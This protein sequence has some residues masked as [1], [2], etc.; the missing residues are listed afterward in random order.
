[1]D[2]LPQRAISW[3]FPFRKNQGGEISKVAT[4]KSG[5]PGSS[6][7]VREQ[8]E[9]NVSLKDLW[10]DVLKDDGT[11]DNFKTLPPRIKKGE[12]ETFRLDALQRDGEEE[13]MLGVLVDAARF[14]FPLYWLYGLVDFLAV[15][16]Y[17]MIHFRLTDDQGFVVQLENHPE[18]ALSPLPLS[19]GG[20][21]QVYSAEQLRQFV[22][23]ASEKNITVM[24]EVDLPGHAA[25]WFQ[26]PG[27]V[28]DCQTFICR[29]GFGVPLNMTYPDIILPIIGRVL[30]EVRDIF[31]TSKY[32]H[33]G[34]DEVHLSTKCYGEVV[35][36]E[37]AAK[38]FNEDLQRFESGL[39]AE[40]GRLGISPDH[41]VR[42]ELTGVFVPIPPR[43]GGD[44]K[45]R[46]KS[47]LSR[48]RDRVG[49]IVH[50]WRG[51]PDGEASF[52]SS[53]L[54]FDTYDDQEGAWYVYQAAIDRLERMPAAVI[55]GTFEL[56]PCS[57]NA[58]NVWGK[59]VAVAMGARNLRNN[60]SDTAGVRDENLRQE[61]SVPEG[62]RWNSDPVVDEGVVA[63]AQHAFLEEYRVVCSSLGLHKGVCNLNGAPKVPTDV[64]RQ[65][66]TRLQEAWKRAV[67]ERRSFA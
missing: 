37:I 58:R 34:G 47:I 44:K 25:S 13:P 17:R 9:R 45:R 57:W 56:G 12:S 36:D 63:E 48:S 3:Q 31:S 10:L 24:P 40:L 8:Q 41:V 67:C 2:H 22:R 20:R 64:W 5:H 7:L 39:A 38:R 53:K 60:F 15:L 30:K 16:G 49:K 33:L 19:I 62:L 59:L 14:F 21:R 43:K 51:I 6:D 55:A 26:I 35:T 42:W 18:L 1:M 4:S 11:C 28:P 66:H 65:S 46:Y 50:Y 23:Y 52:V 61:F 54:Y 29:S 32:I 27:M